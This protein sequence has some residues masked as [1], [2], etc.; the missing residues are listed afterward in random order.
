MIVVQGLLG[1]NVI[2]IATGWNHSVV[3]TDKFDIYTCG[4]GAFGQL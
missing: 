4:H 3:L 1:K 2:Q